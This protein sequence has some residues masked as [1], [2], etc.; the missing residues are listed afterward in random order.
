MY[1]E[2]YTSEIIDYI[3]YLV[4]LNSYLIKKDFNV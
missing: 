2:P 4:S 1:K 3:A